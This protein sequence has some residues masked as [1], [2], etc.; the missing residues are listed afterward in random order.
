VAEEQ[1]W[2]SLGLTPLSRVRLDELLH[3][4]LDRIAEVMTS[5]ERLRSLLDAVVGIGSDLELR[6]TLERIVVSA[7][8]LA[9][10]KYAALGVVG[11]DHKL[12]EF[13]T[14]GIDPRGHAAIG[15]LPTGRGVLGLLIADPRPVRLPDITQHPQSAGFPPHHPPMHSFLGVPIR[16]RDQ[17]FGNLYLAEKQG[18]PEFTDDD[19]EIVVALAAAAGA[20][21]ENAR[22]YSLAQRRQRWLAA[23]AEIITRLSGQVHRDEALSLVARNAREVAGADLVAVL[24]HDEA[25]GTLTVEAVD[26]AAGFDGLLGQ[27]L[28]VAG[29]AFE[30]VLT[31]HEATALEDVGKAAPWP[32]ALPALRGVAAPFAAAQGLMLVASDGEARGAD[33]LLLINAFAAQAGLALERARAR[34]DREQLLV[35]SDRERIARDLHDVVIQRLF[36]SGLQLQTVAGMAAKPEVA[37]RI[38]AVVDDLDATIRD[39]R[40]AIFQLR[41]PVDQ[42]LR[43]EVRALVDA[44]AEHLA[45]RPGLTLDG[46]IDS[47]VPDH[48]RGDLLAVIREALSNVVRHAEA[49]RVD[50][51][52]GVGGGRVTVVVK[53]NGKGGATEH[54]GVRNMRERAEKLGGKCTVGQAE[55]SGTEVVWSVPAS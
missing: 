48:I 7:C 47:A 53:D 4:L 6:S 23:T 18:A 52:L 45:F 17:V 32:V 40:G 22:L 31:A 43:A 29:T 36:A 11:G 21:I 20:A 10:A 9:G 33:E 8:H 26:S 34:E 44:S 41:A 30:S 35:V 12:V 28:D 5:R 50:V 13:I 24:L 19:E 37:S 38:N 51:T 1:Q 15:D 27:R 14:H 46:P 49:S 2:A 3:E 39:I 54:G 25:T 55:P 16:I 42:S